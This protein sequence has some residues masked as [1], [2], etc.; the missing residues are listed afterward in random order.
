MKPSNNSAPHGGRMP[1][2]PH[3]AFLQRH[4]G[5][6]PY[7]FAHQLFANVDRDFAATLNAEAWASLTDEAFEVLRQGPHDTP[8]VRVIDTPPYRVLLLALEDRPF[9]VDSVMNALRVTGHEP[10]HVI[11]PIYKTVRDQAGV[12]TALHPPH[13]LGRYEAF[14]LYFLPLEGAPSAEALETTVAPVLAEVAAVTGAYEAL[15]QR[16]Y[17]LA[18]NLREARAMTAQTPHRERGEALEESAHFLDWLV[19]DN[20]VFLGAAAWP[21]G[22]G[23][24]QDALGLLTG[25]FQAQDEPFDLPEDK[26]LIVTKSE[27]VSRVHRRARIDLVLVNGY[28]DGLQVTQRHAIYGLFTS[29][30]VATPVDE[31]P[32]LRRALARVLDLDDAVPGSHDHKQIVT[33]VD[34][35]PRPELFDS[36]PA[37]L[38]ARVRS[39]MALEQEQGVTLTLRHAERQRGLAAMVVMPRDRFS[40]TVRMRIQTM[41]SEALEAEHADYTL[42]MSEDEAQVRFH[43]FF[44][45]DLTEADVNTQELQ[46]RVVELTRSWADRLSVQLHG[47]HGPQR[48]AQVEARWVHALGERYR[49]D[50]PPARALLDLDFLE[51]LSGPAPLVDT[52][53]VEGETQRPAA[54]ELRVY[55]REGTLP[56]SDV[57]PVLER[58]GLRVLEQVAYNINP[59]GEPF[60]IDAYRVLGPDGRPLAGAGLRERLAAALP[61][62][63]AGEVESDALDRLLLDPG[64]ALRDVA[65]LRAYRMQITQLQPSLSRASVDLALTSTPQATRAILDA[66]HA[67]HDPQAEGRDEALQDAQTRFEAALEGV[68]SLAQDALLRDLMNLVHAT[69][70]SN[71]HT[72]ARVLALKFDAAK[73]ATMPSPRPRFEIAVHGPQVEGTHLRSGPVARGGIRWSDR[74]DDV[75]TEVLGLMK[76]Q[77]V[78][79][80]VIVPVGSK[81][82]FVIKGAPAEPAERAAYARERYREY[83]G[84]LLDVTDNRENGKVVHPDGVV[85]RDGDDPYLVVAADK[86]TA[87]FSD[88]ANEIAVG[89]GFWLGDAFASGGTHGYDHKKLGITA[90]STWVSVDRHLR[91]MGL[92]PQRDVITV[93]G[94]GDMSGD[95][96]GNGLQDRRNLKLVAAFDHRHVFI[97]PNPDPD[98]SYDARAALFEQRRSSWDDYPMD[99]LSDGGMIVPRGAK[100]VQLTPE[101]STLLGLDGLPQSGL[102]LVRAVLRLDVDL[103]WNGGIGTYVKDESERHADVGDTANDAVRINAQELRARVV[104]EGG[105]LGF[106]PLARSAYARMGGRLDS[107]A[108]HNVGGVDLSDREVNL[109]ILLAGPVREGELNADARNALLQ[110]VTDD[111]VNLALHDA[112]QQSLA[113]SLAQ[114]RAARDPDVVTSLHTYL[115][116]EADL[117]SAVEGLPDRKAREARR[118]EG[119]GHTRPELAVLLAYVKMGVYERLL[120]SEVPDEPARTAELQAYLPRAV[121]DA[122]P[123]AVLGH[124]LKREI[125]ATVLTNRLVDLLGPAFVHRTMRDTR[126]RPIEVLT[127]AV[128]AAD[129][130]N[131]HAHAWRLE[132]VNGVH[133]ADRYDAIE[134]LVKA[135]GGVTAWMLLN[136]AAAG[137]E[138][139][140]ES[141]L[142]AR[143]DALEAVLLALPDVVQGADR[144]ALTA[145]LDRF[146]QAGFTAED[147]RRIAA[148]DL[149]PVALEAAEAGR[150]QGVAPEPAAAAFFALGAEL[151]LGWLRDALGALERGGTWEAASAR[152]LVLD[153]R[154]LQR[155]VTGKYLQA[156]KMDADVTPAGFL[157]GLDAI[158]TRYRSA[159]AEVEQAEGVT[160][161]HGVALARQLR[162]ALGG[163]PG[164]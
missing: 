27:R 112:A 144:E 18:R 8:T 116:D 151:K 155:D 5:D 99:A 98:R 71:H 100:S 126:A 7:A 34:S 45:T 149:A 78:K 96:F 105:N 43:F 84:A 20:F 4:E 152:G 101:A 153:L 23:P 19:Q 57:L 118:R 69:V 16:T 141:G 132:G 24:T 56:L 131:L 120:R 156:Q 87:T 158:E 66:F 95:V 106:T 11:H 164:T 97:D 150:V 3:Q 28:E 142:Q 135:A 2:E 25:A 128:R 68:D 134:E 39:V 42:A 59:N 102:A 1:N 160:L 63:I 37:E 64:L 83:I 92:D 58:L 17:E 15:K 119:L 113:L 143:R 36:D 103:L 30:A 33:I 40:G 81:G 26:P 21:A 88:L 89:R 110:D 127:A 72:G 129:L 148:W 67:L 44:V 22:G 140:V 107:D 54:T 124:P 13:G 46:R 82:G 93:A 146:Q 55:H 125:I 70:R 6:V 130:L 50:T 114:R 136:H 104:G 74:P 51:R 157:A 163:L 48:A 91:E 121:A 147:A 47:R 108:I 52:R 109:K 161:A 94:I 9:V 61:P 138:A 79:N 139:E 86:G 154:A 14:E 12:L 62:L 31:T 53:E 75:R 137:V 10:R 41:L 65:L 32:I 145:R 123:Q 90:R 111:V 76:T 159:L 60:G 117:D 73:V 85:V 49:S 133:A 122:Y 162:L 35:M 29:K 80:A 38:H 77:R 115:E